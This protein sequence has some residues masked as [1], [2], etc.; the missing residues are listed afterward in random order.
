MIC[1]AVA[2]ALSLPAGVGL[3]ADASYATLSTCGSGGEGP[4]IGYRMRVNGFAFGL[5]SKKT[6]EY[7][8]LSFY[9]SNAAGEVLL[10]SEDLQAFRGTPSYWKAVNAGL[11]PPK[12]PKPN[13]RLCA[14]LTFVDTDE[15]PVPI[16]A[17]L[18]ALVAAVAPPVADLPKKS[19]AKKAPPKKAKSKSK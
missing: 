2:K 9:G 5:G 18:R 3:S 11:P 17:E 1:E 4:C 6:T 7:L 8:A 19:A 15:E 12:L 10:W 14:L 16:T 13:P